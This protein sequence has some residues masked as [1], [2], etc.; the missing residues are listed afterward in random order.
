MGAE[1]Y[2]RAKQIDKAFQAFFTD[3]AEAHRMLESIE[4]DENHEQG[5]DSL[6]ERIRHKD[7]L[8][9]TSNKLDLSLI[10]I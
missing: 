7:V 5:R 1:N 4:T 2:V 6:L 3:R 10:H 8:L 9:V